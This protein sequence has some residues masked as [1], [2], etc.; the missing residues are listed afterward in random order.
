MLVLLVRL[1]PSISFCFQSKLQ[2]TT[3]LHALSY[4]VPIFPCQN[5]PPIPISHHKNQ[6][7]P[8]PSKP[9]E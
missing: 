1:Y 5:P 7:V 4:I 9:N 8:S 3:P 2:M 6:P